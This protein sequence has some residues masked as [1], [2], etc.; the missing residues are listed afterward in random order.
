MLT[1]FSVQRGV[2]PIGAQG[3][4]RIQLPPEDIASSGLHV[5]CLRR[6]AQSALLNTEEGLYRSLKGLNR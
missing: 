6:K 2:S 5:G 4:L 3:I 1:K